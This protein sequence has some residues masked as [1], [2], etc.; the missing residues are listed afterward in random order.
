MAK[1]TTSLTRSASTSAIAAGPASGDPS[2]ADKKAAAEKGL[3]LFEVA[4][5]KG[6]RARFWAESPSD[7]KDRYLAYFGVRSSDHS[8]TC[9]ESTEDGDGIPVANPDEP[10]KTETP[11]S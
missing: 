5:P 1:K 11:E 9:E 3:K 8:L 10:T 4:I 2:A 7:A 6:Y